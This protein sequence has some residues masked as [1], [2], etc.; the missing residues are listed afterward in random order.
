MNR[1]FLAVLINLL[2]NSAQ[3]MSCG[4]NSHT[5][6]IDALMLKC[7]ISQEGLD[8]VTSQIYN[9]SFTE[10]IF[11]DPAARQ[12]VNNAACGTEYS[13]FI[14]ECPELQRDNSELQDF[15]I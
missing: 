14:I 12:C 15:D 3:N 13:P 5:G 10:S 4:E 6:L 1:L 7:K 8:T 11:H 2:F 9:H